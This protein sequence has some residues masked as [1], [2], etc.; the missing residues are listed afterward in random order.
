MA[1]RDIT[2]RKK[3]E[4]ELRES[5]ER[6]RMLVQ[7]VQDYAIFMLDPEGR[8]VSWNEGAQRIEGYTAEEIIGPAFI[9]RRT[10][11]SASRLVN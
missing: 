5:D 10:S 7:N 3:M 8:V 1:M 11:P 4:R 9:R 6:Y 2:V